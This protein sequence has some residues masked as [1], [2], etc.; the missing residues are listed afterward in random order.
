MLG[1]ETESVVR[2]RR[3]DRECSQSEEE[4]QRDWGEDKG[5]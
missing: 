5:E 4:R 1:G 3:R 2:V